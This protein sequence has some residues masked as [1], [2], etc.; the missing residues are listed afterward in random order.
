MTLTGD[1]GQGGAINRKKYIC[2]VKKLD[3]QVLHWLARD[4]TET[5]VYPSVIL[6]AGT[7]DYTVSVCACAYM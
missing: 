7:Y 5:Y 2:I 1:L 6:C 3:N 4:Y